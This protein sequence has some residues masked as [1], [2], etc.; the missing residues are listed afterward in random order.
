MTFLSIIIPCFNVEEYLPS[1]IASLT[2]LKNAENC[3]FIF[4]NDGS[5]D[6]TL[7]LIRDFAEIDSRVI[8]IDQV[9]QG[10]SAARNAALKMAKGEYLLCLDG[11]DFLH[12]DTLSIIRSHINNADALLAPCFIVTE[13]NSQV[14]NFN[15]PEGLYS[16]ERLYTTCSVFPTSPKIVYR[17]SIIHQH[18]L[19][20]DSLIKSGEVY[21]F[22]VDFLKYANCIAVTHQGFYNYVMR[23]TSAT[24]M[25]NFKADYTVLNILDHFAD[26]DQPWCQTP[27][28]LLTAFKMI[29]SFTYNKY[30]KLGILDR[31]AVETIN[32]VLL[33]T[34]FKILLHT[35]PANQIDFKHK[36]FI[37]YLK[38]MPNKLGYKVC[39]S[40]IKLM[41]NKVFLA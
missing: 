31:Q 28:F 6:S 33:H 11:D 5:T 9:N 4:I 16:V 20:F 10:V 37:Q 14:K 17:T 21:T 19:Q 40:I 22:T 8:L 38:I 41:K 32:S 13:K 18:T 29:M 3:E 39:T 1:T 34:G 15:I 24:H 23:C 36:I 27:S 25:P 12:P 26:V 35:I 7:K 2:C 30:S